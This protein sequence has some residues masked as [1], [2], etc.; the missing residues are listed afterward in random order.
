MGARVFS[1]IL[2]G[3]A[4]LLG[5]LLMPR[6][7]LYAHTS[8]STAYLDRE[9]QLLW[10]S[11]AHD[12]R[13]RLWTELEDIA[14]SLLNA[15]LLYED[16]HFY[17]HPGIDPLALLRAA[18]S[19]IFGQRR[20][21]ASTITMQLARL[22][23]G[24]PHDL[25]GKLQQLA[26][27][28]QIERHYRKEEILT[29][30][31]NLAPYGGNIEGVG[32]ASRIYF[33]KPASELSRAEALALSLIP[34]NP[35]ARNP[36]TAAGLAQLM[37]AHHQLAQRWLLRHG[38]QLPTLPVQFHTLRQLPFHAPHL[39][40]ALHYGGHAR[41][42]EQ[43]THLDLAVQGGIETLL[44]R[45][46]ASLRTLGVDNGAVMVVDYRDMGV[47]AA[48]GSADYF[49]RAIEGQVDGSRA[50]R[51]PGSALKPFVYALALEQG[52]IH[53]FSL[54]HDAPSQHGIYTPENFDQHFSGPLFAQDALNYSRN[55]PAVNLLARL[56]APG[57]HG[58]LRQAG[59]RG[60][61]EADH[62]GLALVL[63]GMEIRMDEMAALYAMLANRGAYRPVQYLRNAQ[64]ET[65]QQLLMPEAAWLTLEMLRH[66]EGLFRSPMPGAIAREFPDVAWKTGTSHAY[67]DAW[68]V[69]VSG[70]YV[71]AVWLGHFDGRGNPALVGR[72]AAGPLLFDIIEHLA[73]RDADWPSTAFSPAG[74]KLHREEMCATGGDLPGR[75]CPRTLPGWFIPGVSPLRV[76]QIHRQIPLLPNGLRAC[77]HRPPETHLQVVEFWPS[78]LRKIFAQA[79]IR[80][81]A[82]PPFEA[83]C[84]L[85]QQ[86]ASGQAPQIRSPLAGLIY[87]L[88]QGDGEFEAI[89][90][91]ANAEGDVRQLY[92]FV[93]KRLI[94]TV[95][96]GETLF[97]PAEPGQHL[98]RV[99]DDHGRAASVSLTVQHR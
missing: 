88:G 62:Y 26:R 7:D 22:R 74:L 65:A 92:W 68:A 29:A 50:P 43:L 41:A 46:L 79:G 38:E 82:P 96:A 17:R 69:A 11:L 28:I 10:L 48:V 93:G 34:Q 63:G 91:Q 54:L 13:Y 40:Q 51:S 25:G 57:L 97:W 5:W 14:P 56:Q 89:P 2:L 12:E 64:T 94:A 45:H 52:L 85:E 95:A 55:V 37:T 98:L 70:P 1:L 3:A 33:T 9:G 4:L 61:K 24:L 90:L 59:V 81:P 86:A 58:L 71:I 23:Y 20:F 80:K 19:T 87:T 39:V 99:V 53:P 83:G 42:G 36:V 76:E 30:Y 32:A 21:G 31:L 8:F 66:N 77:R 44:Q 84:D 27:A 73:R 67:R 15:T 47:R 75:H 60:L 78:E 16:R 35:G 18:W 6:P 49:N 72:T